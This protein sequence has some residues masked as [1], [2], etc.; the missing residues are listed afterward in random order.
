MENFNRELRKQFLLTDT[1]CFIIIVTCMCFS[2]YFPYNHA[3]AIVYQIGVLFIGV[4]WC[5]VNSCGIAVILL[6]NTTREYIAISTMDSFS[7]Y[8][9]MNSGIMIAFILMLS[10]LKLYQRG[11]KVR[12]NIGRVILAILG[13]QM[14][15]S[16]VWATNLDEY[17]VYFPV[18]CCIYMLGALTVEENSANK[19]FK[20]AFMFSG[21]FMAI[22]VIPYYI[23]H[24]S[25]QELTVL[26]NGNGLLVDRNYQSLFL[27]LC[28]LNSLLLVKE[29]G[30][31][32]NI[33]IKLIVAAVVTGDVFI[34][35]VGAS[36]SAILGLVVA[37]I[38]Y[39]CV[40]ARS[41]GGNVKL[42]GVM[43][44]LFLFAYNMGLLEPI[45]IRF[46]ESDVASGNGRFDL[47]IGYLSNFE[48]GNLTQLF[49]GRG[50]IGKSI[51]G[52]PAHNLFVSILF[53]FGILGEVLLLS[54]CGIIVIKAL[55]VCR[56]E[57]VIIIPLLFMC[58]TLEPYYRIEFALYMACIPAILESR[59]KENKK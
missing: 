9:S 20:M 13:L 46:A 44:I 42:V 54:Y 7:T 28:I 52:A 40:N 51:V 41:V 15:M 59:K 30:K 58:C 6:L 48:R 1:K 37:V 23:S 22:G 17:N 29:Y 2:L 47:W 16:Q 26:I 45:F 5:R 34:I 14:L 55:Q 31:E 43:V 18:V 4:W 53:S 24:S 50:L 8:Y 12:F 10:A 39:I 56:E 32:I 33:I 49:F 36:R 3:I 27:M 25:L 57:L 38:V 11:W 35:V 19:T 21:F